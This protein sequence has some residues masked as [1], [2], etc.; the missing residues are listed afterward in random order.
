MQGRSREDSAGVA[1]ISEAKA[2]VVKNML[3]ERE[4]LYLSTGLSSLLSNGAWFTDIGKQ[5]F[6]MEA[7]PLQL[8][9]RL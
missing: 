6:W 8:T 3:G 4:V 1:I 9:D 7:K 5:S 2:C